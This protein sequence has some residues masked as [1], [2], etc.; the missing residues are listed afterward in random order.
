MKNYKFSATKK[1]NLYALMAWSDKYSREEA[2]ELVNSL[3]ISELEKITYATESIE[4][5]INGVIEKLLEGLITNHNED[6]SS[7]SKDLDLEW[8]SVIRILVNIHDKWVKSNPQKY[9]RGSKEK[10]NK[11]LFQHLPTGLIGI[12]ELAKDLMF[13]APFLEELGLNAGE[14]ELE[15]Y[16]SFKPSED[17][18][19]AYDRYVERI[20]KAY[21]I[22]SVEDL[23]MFI[24][25]CLDGGYYYPLNPVDEIS[26][27]RNEYMQKNIGVLVMAVANKNKKAFGSLPMRE[28]E[29]C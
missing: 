4:I 17:V 12:D 23:S 26:E 20:K 22:E 18:I 5:A 21:G 15:P 19:K 27:A 1:A 14:M 10:S 28:N 25:G 9:D 2:E 16:G 11:N 24:E 7:D 3:D 8:D 13:L 29:N 6:K